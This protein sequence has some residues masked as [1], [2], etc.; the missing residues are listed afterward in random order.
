MCLD[1]LYLFQHIS[2]DVDLF[3]RDELRGP[4]M[5]S[6]SFL[7]A[8]W[9]LFEIVLVLL[10]TTRLWIKYLVCLLCFWN[11]LT[12]VFSLIFRS[13][14]CCVMLCHVYVI[15]ELLPFWI[16]VIYVI[17][18]YTKRL[19]KYSHVCSLMHIGIALNFIPRADTICTLF[20]L[21]LW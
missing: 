15:S 5:L 3:S 4:F 8:E 17:K 18:S 20:I 6:L 7:Q 13:L 10:N 16:A 1:F 19:T 9:L 12:L 14:E 11:E 2:P 21:L